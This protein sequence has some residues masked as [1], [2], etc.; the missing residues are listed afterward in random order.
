MLVQG[1][2]LILV[3]V[4]HSATAPDIGRVVAHKLGAKV[5]PFRGRSGAA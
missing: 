2:R 3:A 4:V 5:M 1:A